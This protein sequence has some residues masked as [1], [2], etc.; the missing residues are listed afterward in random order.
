M[1]M[2][3]SLP[4][5][6]FTKAPQEQLRHERRVAEL[7]SN[8]LFHFWTADDPPAVREAQIADWLDDLVEYN[9]SIV[10]EA[11]RMWRRAN[12]R[13]PTPHDIRALC[14][15]EI[16]YR[17]P[18]KRDP[19]PDWEAI[20]QQRHEATRPRTPEEIAYVDERLRQIREVLAGYGFYP[21]P[22]N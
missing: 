6:S 9:D 1:D 5:K 16:A 12:S 13:R 21:K 20:A 15:A 17:A 19:E 4:Q 18:R 7:V 11:L 22:V 8:L 14:Q 3:E 10:E 2:T